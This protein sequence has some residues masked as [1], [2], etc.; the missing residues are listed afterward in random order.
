MRRPPSDNPI[1]KQFQPSPPRQ[2]VRVD[3]AWKFKCYECWKTKT[4]RRVALVEDDGERLVVNVCYRQVRADGTLDVLRRWRAS[5]RNSPRIA[6]AA[7]HHNARL[8]DEA[9]TI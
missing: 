7:R 6:M 8:P 3:G 4:A 1:V 9:G 5:P 2:Q